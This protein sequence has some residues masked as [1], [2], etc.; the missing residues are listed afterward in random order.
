MFIKIGLTHDFRRLE[1][2]YAITYDQG[3]KFQ[4]KINLVRSV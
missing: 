2:D 4:Q 1:T 3:T